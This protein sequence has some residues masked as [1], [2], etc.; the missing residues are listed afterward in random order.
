LPGKPFSADGKPNPVDPYAISKW[1]AENGLH[2][3]AEQT[4]MEVV[5]IRPPLVYGAGVKANFKMMMDW[6]GLGVPLPLGAIYNKRSFV[7]LDNLVDLI[8]TCI[9]HPAAANQTFL[10]ADNEDVSTTKLLQ[11]IGDALGKPAR[12]IPVPEILL[13]NAAVVLGK[14]SAAERL[15]GSLQVDISKTRDL[16]GWEPPLS[17]KKGLLKIVESAENGL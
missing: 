4:D 9:K 13:R 2:A 12:L 1:E 11:L 3:I 14:K 5:V 17:L 16:L 10:A 6:V 7:A 8:L 15:L